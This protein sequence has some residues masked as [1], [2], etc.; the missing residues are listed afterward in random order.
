M[1]SS[2]WDVA[3]KWG[4]DEVGKFLSQAR[5]EA[6]LYAMYNALR[7]QSGQGSLNRPAVLARNWIE[8]NKF[9]GGTMGRFINAWE[10]DL[11]IGNNP[12]SFD[13]NTGR[14]TYNDPRWN[15]DA[16]SMQSFDGVQDMAQKRAILDKYF[17]NTPMRHLQN[18]GR[19][20]YGRDLYGRELDMAKILSG[21]WSGLPQGNIGPN[22]G[23]KWITTGPNG[24]NVNA[25]WQ[26]D[27]EK[28]YGSGVWGSG[29]R[30]AGAAPPGS[31][32]PYQG[33]WG[34]YSSGSTPGAQ[35]NSPAQAVTN[36]Q[37][38]GYER[39]VAGSVAPK[40]M[41]Q[42]VPTSPMTNS[43]MQAAT[44]MQNTNPTN[45]WTRPGRPVP[46]RGFPRLYN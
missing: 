25:N 44:A 24:Q 22:Y 28:V 34:G 7:N 6:E 29:G 46:R 45:M 38:T 37:N 23:P 21:Q 14:F 15:W 4:Y 2:F 27:L 18:F 43:P 36:M 12:V 5:N 30:P 41:S 16:L 8:Q 11:G 35:V 32:T 40:A 39:G 26:S 1:A 20:A 42:P 33:M 13:I 10:G 19:D 17:T 3:N 9:G 31:G